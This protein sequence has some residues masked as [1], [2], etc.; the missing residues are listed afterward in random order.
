MTWIRGP[1]WDGFFILSGLPIGLLLLTL[2]PDAL[3]TFFAL[4][5]LLETGHSLS[6]ILLAWSHPSLRQRML[7][8]PGKCIWLPTAV[9]TAALA[10]GVVTSMGWSSYTPGPR[11]IWRL[12]DA[13]NL[14]PVVMWVY[15]VWNIY[16]F[17]MQ[18]FGIV[19]LYRRKR[20]FDA[21]KRMFI[22]YGCLA[23]TAFG[24]AGIPLVTRSMT[25]GLICLGAFAVSHWMQAI[26]L[27]SAVSQYGRLFAAGAL[28]LGCVGFLWMVPTPRG[29]IINVI[30][31]VICARAGLGFVHFLYDRWLWRRDCAAALL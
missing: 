31:A 5:V 10:V 11:Q 18:N 9:F 21:R 14:L 26:G 2:S 30:P 12:T 8:E 3:L 25:V 28:L 15:W 29:T 17:G 16:H 6:P 7:G 19:Q 4:V 13:A 1:W 20:P 27:C 23:G 22:K 24:M